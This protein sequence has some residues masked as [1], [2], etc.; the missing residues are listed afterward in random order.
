[1]HHHPPPPKIYLPP[2]TTTHNITTTTQIKTPKYA[3]THQKSIGI[4]YHH[5]LPFEKLI[6]C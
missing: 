3:K 5:V 6:E 2:L 1:M 4:I